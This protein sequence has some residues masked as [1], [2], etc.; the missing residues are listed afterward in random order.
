VPLLALVACLLLAEEPAA[1]CPAECGYF[2]CDA[3]G[4]CLTACERDSDCADGA[5]CEDGQCEAECVDEACPGGFACD[6]LANGCKSQ[7][8]NDLHC[9][10]GYVCDGASCVP[11]CREGSCDDGYACDYDGTC[12][13]ECLID[14]H[15]Q[16]GWHCCDYDERGCDYGE[17][18]RD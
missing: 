14:D 6:L 10:D 4:A 12:R 18:A 2:D 1:R 15:C 7:C 3:S 11:E 5:T 9:K 17:C 8:D 13:T 16:A